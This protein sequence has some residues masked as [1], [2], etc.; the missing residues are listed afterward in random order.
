MK[1]S[2]V[3]YVVCLMATT[4]LST[5]V[6]ANNVAAGELSYTWL[7]G[8]TY[9]FIYKGYF[10]CSGSPAPASIYL[11]ATNTCAN[12]NTHYMLTKWTGS[13]TYGMPN[14]SNVPVGCLQPKTLCESPSSALRGF[15]EYW[16]TAD[17]TLTDT[18]SN[19]QF[20]TTVN[21]RTN[22]DN[23]VAGN[24]YLKVT[25]NNTNVQRN[26]TPTFTS[27]AIVYSSKYEQTD[28]N[29]HLHDPDGDSLV[30]ELVQPFTHSGTSNLCPTTSSTVALVPHTPP[31]SFPTNPFP[32]IGNT[33]F[34]IDT[35]N[36]VHVVP[37]TDGV[38]LVTYLVKEY[39][40]GQLI[41][42]T[43]RDAIF[44]INGNRSYIR[45]ELDTAGLQGLQHFNPDTYLSCPGDTIRMCYRF[46]NTDTNARIY[47]FD[48][49]NKVLPGVIV[50]YSGQ[51]SDTVFACMEWLPSNA[52]TG[53]FAPRFMARDSTCYPPG[54]ANITRTYKRIYVRA[55]PSVSISKHWPNPAWPYV[56]MNFSATITPC[57]KSWFQWQ[58][59]GK[60]VPNHPSNPQI[61]SSTQLNDGDHVRCLYKCYDTLCMDTTVVT[62][63]TITVNMKT[64]I[65]VTNSSDT[66]LAIYPNPNNGLFAISAPMA[67]NNNPWHV[68]IFNIYGQ[69]VYATDNYLSG[70]IDISGMAPGMY[71]LMLNDGEKQYKANFVVR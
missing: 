16:Y 56:E 8:N 19:W 49:L 60:D 23:V 7:S 28:L 52:D 65:A 62:S 37:N 53:I 67:K 26:S 54:I 14:G 61:W 69:S 30:L 47:G 21:S 12:T 9:R 20:V 59:N 42:T 68:L 32:T 43:L 36:D 18:C 31:L 44:V 46:T 63:N 4:L 5:R 11:C 34:Y 22:F 45:P 6:S 24:Q 50:S 35:L 1:L 48:T 70:Q 3:I 29:N 51:G 2:W 39:R 58:V 38:Y 33:S 66:R 40:N 10:D 71:M 57:F 27:P 13:I 41:V 17:I 64:G 15:R 55:R 25:F